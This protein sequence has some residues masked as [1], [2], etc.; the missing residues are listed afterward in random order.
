MDE[1]LVQC[2]PG[3]QRIFLLRYLLNLSKTIVQIICFILRRSFVLQK[4][5]MKGPRFDR[6]GMHSQFL[7]YNR[8][9]KE[10]EI[11]YTFQEHFP[12]QNTCL[13]VNQELCHDSKTKYRRKALLAQ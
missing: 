12:I 11:R 8:N 1:V 6:D 3:F 7:T 5:I 2:V 13:D 4:Y 9:S 10:A